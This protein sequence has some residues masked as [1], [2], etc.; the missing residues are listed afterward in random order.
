MLNIFRLAFV[1]SLMLASVLI[2]GCGSSLPDV[3]YVTGVVTLDGKPLANAEVT[4]APEKGRGSSGITDETGKYEL[5]YV[6]GEPGA[7]IGAH[8][9]MITSGGVPVEGEENISADASD[10]PDIAPRRKPT[11]P[12]KGGIPAKYNS[13]TT[14]T[15]DVQSGSNT[16]DFKLESK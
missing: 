11:G 2:S 1:C 7:L 3:G 16:F 13:K 10:E 15:A 12:K 4:F 8:K 9:V 6:A 14:L 5:F